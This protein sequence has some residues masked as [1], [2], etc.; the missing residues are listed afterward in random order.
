VGI[1]GSGPYFHDGRYASLEELLEKSK[2]KMGSVTALTPPERGAL[3]SYLRT[4]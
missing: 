3:L 2:G 4:L 1:G